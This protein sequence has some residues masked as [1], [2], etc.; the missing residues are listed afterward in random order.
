V[1]SV[2]TGRAAEVGGSPL[3]QRALWDLVADHLRP[4]DIVLAD[5]GTAFYGMATHRLPHDVTFL[6]QPLWASIGY[7]L[8]AALGACLAAPG[9]RGI[10]LIGDGA[11]HMTV[12]A[13]STIMRRRLPVLVVVVDND[14][15]TVERAIHGPDEPY[16]DI[17]RWDWTALPS[18]L[19]ADRAP[20]AHRAETAGEVE[21][22]LADADR[23]PAGVTLIQAVVPRMDVPDLLSALTRAL[24]HANAR[25]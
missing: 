15:Y 24:S 25:T 11:A 7:T 10:V 22:A 2:S 4:G 16:N 21:A 5:Q 1:P 20:R 19:G 3:S 18:A 9:R 6:G 14:G 13:L 23:G 12:Q 8:P 17:P